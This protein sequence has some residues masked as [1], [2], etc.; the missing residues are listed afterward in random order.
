MMAIQL[1]ELDEPEVITPLPQRRD[2]EAVAPNFGP[3][4]RHAIAA[5][6]GI[7]ITIF[8]AALVLYGTIA[9]LAR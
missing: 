3:E 2:R 7:M 5:L 1:L 6:F 9:L 4:D 8:S